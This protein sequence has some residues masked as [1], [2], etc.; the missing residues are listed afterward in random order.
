MREHSDCMRD[1]L[2]YQSVH[3]FHLAFILK[4]KGRTQVQCYR[5]LSLKDVDIAKN[6]QIVGLND[7]NIK[8]CIYFFLKNLC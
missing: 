2:G 8:Q 6:L 7:Q 4:Y 1:I 5:K 3:I